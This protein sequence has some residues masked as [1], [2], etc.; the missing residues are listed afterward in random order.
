MQVSAESR[1]IPKTDSLANFAHDVKV[2]E[3]IVVGVQDRGEKFAGG[4]QVAE[5]GARVAVADGA[6]AGF[7]DGALV[8]YIFC[9]LDEQ[10]ALRSKQAAVA[11][12]ARTARPPMA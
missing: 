6:G 11:R 7:V 9:V 12:A 8:A 10:A 5:I 3:K 2:K 4:V 1:Q